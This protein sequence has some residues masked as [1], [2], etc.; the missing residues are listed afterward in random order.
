LEVNKLYNPCLLYS[1]TLNNIKNH[2]VAY[3][4]DKALKILYPAEVNYTQ[5][6][7]VCTKAALF[8]LASLPLLN[9]LHTS[10]GCAFKKF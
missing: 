10:Q 6:I 3:F 7:A 1:E 8:M 9:V 4:T 5:T 2:P